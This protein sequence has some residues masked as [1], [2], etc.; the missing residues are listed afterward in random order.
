MSKVIWRD[1]WI[2]SH[3]LSYGAFWILWRLHALLHDQ[4]RGVRQLSTIYRALGR[5]SQDFSIR[6]VAEC[7]KRLHPSFTRV[8]V[9]SRF[10][11]TWDGLHPPVSP[12]RHFASLITTTWCTT[13]G[14]PPWP[15]HANRACPIHRWRSACGH[16]GTQCHGGARCYWPG[17]RTS[18]ANPSTAN[19]FSSTWGWT[20][21]EA[22]PWRT[23]TPYSPYLH[24]HPPT[25]HGTPWRHC[26]KNCGPMD[27][28]WCTIGS[29]VHMGSL[30][31]S[32]KHRR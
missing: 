2:H 23:W 29:T 24:D 12:G 21:C 16:A 10:G 17:Q 9:A 32:P 28:T 19:R 13:I 31:S 1:P 14:T 7:G 4:G 30:L 26:Q 11:R 15:S 22:I 20:T 5:C 8:T 3:D 6:W 27:W 18:L 25:P